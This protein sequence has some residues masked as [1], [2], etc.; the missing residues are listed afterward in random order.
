MDG[1]FTIPTDFTMTLILIMAVTIVDIGGIIAVIMDVRPL[2]TIP[3]P[4]KEIMVLAVQDWL[5]EVML[6]ET[7]RR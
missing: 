6:F 2:Y 3:E 5:Q 7:E 4:Y 1:D